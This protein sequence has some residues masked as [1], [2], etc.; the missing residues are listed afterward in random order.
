M[1]AFTKRPIKHLRRLNTMKMQKGFT[2]IELMIVI[3]ILGIL[4]AIA[5]PAYQDYTIRAKVSECVNLAAPA[6]LALADASASLGKTSI[7]A[8]TAAEA[9][10]AFTT[11]AATRNCTS[12]AVGAAGIITATTTATGATVDPIL[13]LTPAQTTSTD[14][15]RW[16]CSVSAGL[17]KHVPANCR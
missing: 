3:A 6:K 2:L 8:L 11:P 16:T 17:D 7:T 15:V 5:I 1:L 9:A 10:D 4:M 13:L 14:P 12:V